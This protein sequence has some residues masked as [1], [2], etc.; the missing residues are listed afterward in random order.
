VQGALGR[1]STEA[2]GAGSAGK[3]QSGKIGTF[4]RMCGQKGE[5]KKR[6]EKVRK[7]QMEDNRDRKREE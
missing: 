5:S 6:K 3:P 4:T 2:D 7:G 1:N